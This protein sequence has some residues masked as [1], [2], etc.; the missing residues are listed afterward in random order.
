[1]KKLFVLCLVVAMLLPALPNYSFGRSAK[2]SSYTSSD[3]KPKKHKHH[4]EYKNGWK[5][6]KSYSSSIDGKHKKKHR[7]GPNHMSRRQRK[8]LRQQNLHGKPAPQ[9][10]LMDD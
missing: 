8:A 6:K 2:N 3:E 10:K 5:V 1:V 7:H 4:R 9:Q